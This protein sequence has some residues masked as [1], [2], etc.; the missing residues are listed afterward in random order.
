M[1]NGNGISPI[2]AII[3]TVLVAV[4]TVV[5]FSGGHVFWGIVFALITVDFF[6]DLIL[7][8]RRS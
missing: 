5:F 1:K 3:L 2:V 4:L 6:A 8:F 7:S